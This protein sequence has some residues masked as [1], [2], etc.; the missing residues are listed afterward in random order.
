MKNRF[1]QLYQS[2]RRGRSMEPKTRLT[3][4]EVDALAMRL[5]MAYRLEEFRSEDDLVM[6]EEYC[7]DVLLSDF[8]ALEPDELQRMLALGWLK[9]NVEQAI[10]Q[11]RKS[12]LASFP[13]RRE[14]EEP[15]SLSAAHVVDG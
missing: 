8:D 14:S 7:A 4:Q 9:R 5:V 11:G 10:L 2:A 6:A 1:A 3:T 13:K 12:L 15:R